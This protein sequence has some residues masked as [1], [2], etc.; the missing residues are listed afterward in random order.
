LLSA[1]PE[2]GEWLTATDLIDLHQSEED[3]PTVIDLSG[4]HPELVPEWVVWTM[5]ELERRQL[6]SRIY[7]WSDDNLSCDFFWRFLTDSQID[8]V[9]SYQNYGRVGCFKGFDPVS[10]HFNTSADKSFYDKQFTLFSRYHK[11][12]I[13]LYAYV[14]LTTPHVERIPDQM[15]AFV[16]RLQGIHEHLPLRTVPL[17]I[18]EFSPVSTRMTAQRRLALENQW[19]AVDAWERERQ[20]RFTGS[21]LAQGITTVTMND[22]G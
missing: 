20:R 13:D 7:L 2:R 18:R 21:M 19:R 6:T 10:F 15:A 9:A 17:L 11:L 16:D 5:E 22:R 8:R 4:G 3:P 12:G 1:N 14:T